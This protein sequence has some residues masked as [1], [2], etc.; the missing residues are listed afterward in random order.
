MTVAFQGFPMLMGHDFNVTLEAKDRPNNVRGQDLDSKGFWTFIS[1]AELH[2]MGPVECLYT[3]RN[4]NGDTM[5][6]WL[7]RF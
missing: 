6:S 3:W 2:L 4:T 5:A 7:D 1:K